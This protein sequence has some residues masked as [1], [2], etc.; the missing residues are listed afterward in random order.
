[1][2]FIEQRIT[3]DSF[4]LEPINEK[5]PL[6]PVWNTKGEYDRGTTFIG[7]QSPVNDLTG[8][9]VT[10]MSRE[11]LCIS[12]V[13]A[14]ISCHTAMLSRHSGSKAT[15]H[16]SFSGMSFSRWTSLSAKSLC[17]L[18]FLTT[19]VFYCFYHTRGHEVCQLFFYISSSTILLFVTVHSY[20]VPVT[21]FADASHS[22]S[23]KSAATT[24]SYGIFSSENACL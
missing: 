20:L 8:H 6:Y 11:C 22:K 16:I 21:D 9:P 18:L 1:M 17:V 15:F 14:L 3:C 4:A 10:W 12:A 7:S 13:S 2:I 19:F 5:N 24:V 23:A